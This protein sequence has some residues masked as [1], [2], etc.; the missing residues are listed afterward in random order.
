[1]QIQAGF[2][3]ID[4]GSFAPRTTNGAASQTEEYATN[5]VIADQYLFDGATEEGIQT[6][7][8]MPDD[9]D[10]GTIKAKFYWDAASGASAS[11]GVTWG[12]SA[13]AKANSDAIDAAFAASIDTDDVMITVGDVHISAA[14]GA[15]TV[16]NTAVLGDLTWFEVTRVVD[17][18]QDDMTEDA[19]FLGVM[20]QYKKLNIEAAAW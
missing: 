10:L 19:K 8:S 1:M 9:W 18:A 6:K 3:W 2:V 20:I 5:D 17:D 12:L 11:D 7:I 13:T 4:A 15:V 16:D 14:S